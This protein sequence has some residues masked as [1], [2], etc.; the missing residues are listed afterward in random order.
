MITRRETLVAAVGAAAAPFVLSAKAQ[1]AAPIKIGM[2]IA[3]S[4]PIVSAGKASLLAYQIWAED[5]NARGG[6]LGR[7][8]ELVVY[9]D[10]SSPTTVPGITLSS[11]TSTR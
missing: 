5:V 1:S 7:K 8:V 4:G 6:I 11:W 3:L 2:G 9:D 10:Q